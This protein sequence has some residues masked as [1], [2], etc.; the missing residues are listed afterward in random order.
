MRNDFRFEFHKS[1]ET[2][3][4]I[5]YC[6]T[7]A[8]TRLSRA[9]IK[10]RMSFPKWNPMKIGNKMPFFFFCFSLSCDHY[11]NI[12]YRMDSEYDHIFSNN[13]SNE[14]IQKYKCTPILFINAVH[15]IG[16]AIYIV[17]GIHQRTHIFF[18]LT[19]IKQL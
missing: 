2:P 3:I 7:W 14:T 9:K 4:V 15:K 19:T 13:W 8:S 11:G 10:H 6:D 5:A 18:Y 12:V 16:N 1:I 17:K